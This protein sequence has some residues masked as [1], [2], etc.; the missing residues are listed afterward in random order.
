M[1]VLKSMSQYLAQ[2]QNFSVTIRDGYD[3]VQQS[4]QK[5]EFGELRKV[6]VSR[7]D[8][9]RIEVERS[10]GEKNLVIFNGKE[11]TVYTAKENVYATFSREGT[12]DQVIKY[13]L[14]NLK[15]RVPLAMMLLSTLPSEL[16]KLIL[17]ADYVETTTITDVPCDHLAVRTNR[18]VDFQVW[19]AQGSQPLPRRIVITYKDD[20]GQ[21]QFWADLSN[22]NLAP[23]IS[24]ALFAFTPPNG[25]DRI[26]F[27]A[28]L[29]HA[30]VT[31]TPEKGANQ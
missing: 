17:S 29:G 15:I 22:W 11:L 27:L 5:I 23:E 8:R 21:P 6:T 12:L 26:E 31:A 24:D 7:P 4:G 18:G 16:D 3:A 9:L 30:G 28:G 14:E 25:A 20:P 10:D 2:A 19:V 1:S 13:A